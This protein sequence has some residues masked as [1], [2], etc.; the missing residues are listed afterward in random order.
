MQ[1][2]KIP[3]Q[4]LIELEGVWREV[5]GVS[6]DGMV[7]IDYDTEQRML[8]FIRVKELNW[9]WPRRLEA[10]FVEAGVPA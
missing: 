8:P 4:V 1:F 3:T 5:L 10:V 2:M 9:L 7:A 6:S